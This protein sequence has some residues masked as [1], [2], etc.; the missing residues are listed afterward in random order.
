MTVS[1]LIS[2]LATYPA[3]TRV[4][5]L[6]PDKQWLLPIKVTPQPA[7]GSVRDVDFIAITADATSDEIEGLVN[8]PRWLGAT[9]HPAAGRH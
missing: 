2:M 8:G 3:E 5:L 9:P 4:T 7:D 6:D 1:E